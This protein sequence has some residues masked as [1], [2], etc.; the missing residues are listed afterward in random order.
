MLFLQLGWPWTHKFWCQSCAAYQQEYFH[1]TECLKLQ[2]SAFLS[3]F[4]IF[5]FCSPAADEKLCF[6]KIKPENILKPCFGFFDD[7]LNEYWTSFQAQL[8]IHSRGQT[9]NVS[10]LFIWKT[11]RQVSS[12][13][14]FL[15]DEAFFMNA[16]KNVKKKFHVLFIERLCK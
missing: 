2:R 7:V 12:N 16:F 5:R 10:F 9:L 13:R 14:Q 1:W 6:V 15:T 8:L 3:D 11:L 4:Y